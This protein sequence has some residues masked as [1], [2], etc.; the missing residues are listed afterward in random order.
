M[1][2]ETGTL[3]RKTVLFH[4]RFH[5]VT[6]VVQMVANMES[7]VE[8]IQGKVVVLSVDITSPHLSLRSLATE[9]ALLAFRGPSSAESFQ[10]LI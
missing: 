8:A 1:G 7:D 10:I 3:F 2:V 6:D 5:S 4:A 9:A